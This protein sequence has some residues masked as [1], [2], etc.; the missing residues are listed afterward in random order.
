MI[1]DSKLVGFIAYLLDSRHTPGY[2]KLIFAN[3]RSTPD[4]HDRG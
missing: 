1:D 3:N 4:I 2:N